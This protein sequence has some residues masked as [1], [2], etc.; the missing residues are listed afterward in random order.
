MSIKPNPVLKPFEYWTQRVLP[1][2]YDDSMSYYEVLNAVVGYLNEVIKSQN[3]TNENFNALNDLF[4][5]LKSFVDTYFNDLDVQKEIN[6]K[7]D[8]LVTNGT[9]DNIINHNI[10]DDLNNKLNLIKEKKFSP[11]VNMSLYTRPGATNLTTQVERFKKMN[12][13]GMYV[14]LSMTYDG[15]LEGNL[16]NI[17]NAINLARSYGIEVRTIKFHYTGGQWDNENVQGRYSSFVRN[18]M[19][20]VEG[21][22]NVYI[23]NEIAP[24]VLA[25]VQNYVESVITIV[26]SDGKTCGIS[27]NKTFDWYTQRASLSNILAS[28]DYLGFNRY[29]KISFKYTETTLK[30]SIDAW[31]DTNFPYLLKD[32]YPALQFTITEAGVL[33]WYNFLCAPYLWQDTYKTGKRDETVARIFFYG[34]FNSVE[35]IPEVTTW[36]TEFYE[37]QETYDFFKYYLG[38]F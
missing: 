1:Q 3:L 14:C 4:V 13:H 38:G 19:N 33:P 2:V 21:I 29:P 32:T 20:I 6:Y 18:H 27:T 26:K 35:G 10:F 15:N 12:A 23:F 31:Q 8:E 28:I 37:E 17:I 36:F 24:S 22:E 9:L 7:L 25:S 30:D 16:E 34:L 5:N 11:K